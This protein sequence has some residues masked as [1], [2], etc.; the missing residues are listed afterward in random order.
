MV[1]F[2]LI[3]VAGMFTFYESRLRK[4][5]T[6]IGYLVLTIGIIAIIGY[7]V[8]QPTLYYYID[9]VSSAMAIHT[10]ILFVLL[11]IALI[12]SRNN[13]TVQHGESVKIYAKITFLFLASSLIPII[14]IV[15]LNLNIL[16]D[17]PNNESIKISMI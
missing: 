1:N 5:I 2:I 4:L 7:V 10:A 14:F 16:E 6:P 9:N 17:F 13:I 3:I 11:G 15:G 12:F 8:N